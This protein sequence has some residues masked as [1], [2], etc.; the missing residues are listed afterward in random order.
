MTTS[1]MTDAEKIAAVEFTLDGTLTL[2]TVKLALG[3]DHAD[4]DGLLRLLIASF[5]LGDKSRW[6]L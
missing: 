4:S 5:D 6:N 3:I 2:E 1:A